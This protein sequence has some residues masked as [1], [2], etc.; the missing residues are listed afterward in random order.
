LIGDQSEPALH[1]VQPR[2]IGRREVQMKSW[3][4]GEPR[5]DSR[6]F[7]SAVVVADQMYIGDL[8]SNSFRRR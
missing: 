4:L 5:P 8:G 2:A 3:T 1:L 7:V 6:V